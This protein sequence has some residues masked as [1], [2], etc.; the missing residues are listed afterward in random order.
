M[1]RRHLEKFRARVKNGKTQFPGARGP[2]KTTTLSGMVVRNFFTFYV[3]PDRTPRGGKSRNTGILGHFG[4]WHFGKS[5]AWAENGKKCNFPALGVPKARKKVTTLSGMVVRN[6]FTLCVLTDRTP[7][8]GK[9]QNTGLLGPF[10][11]GQPLGNSGCGP[12]TEKCDFPQLGALLGKKPG[13][14]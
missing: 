4:L 12:E 7:R 8:G 9:S 14:P 10:G 11:L 13:H 1:G 3:L 2:K 5:R 6:F